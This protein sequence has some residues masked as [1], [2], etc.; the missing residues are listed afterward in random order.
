[1]RRKKAYKMQVQSYHSGSH[2]EA[3][4]GAHSHNHNHLSGAGNRAWD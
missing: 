2:G 3:D 4:E 1:M